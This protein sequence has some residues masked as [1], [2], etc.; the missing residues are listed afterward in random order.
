MNEFLIIKKYLSKLSQGNRGSLKLSDDIFFDYKK[1]IAISVDTFVEK[2]HFLD[3]KNSNL[4][5]K[6]ILR[7]SISDLICKGIKPKYYFIAFSGN[8][9]HLNK[10][11]LSKIYFSL[12][13]E[14]KKYNIILSGGDISFS[15]KLSI[16]ITVVGYSNIK[17]ILRSGAKHNDDIYITNNVGDSFVGQLLLKNKINKSIKN[18]KYFINSFYRPDL[19]FKFSKKIHLFANSSIDLSDGLFQD[20][21]HVLSFSNLTSI[22]Y[23]KNI[24]ISSKLKAYLKKYKKNKLNFISNGD[25][26]QIL[27]TANSNKRKLINQIS[28]Q[29][30][31]KVTKIGIVK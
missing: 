11:K 25:D 22:I 23:D 30:S 3:F 8:K 17:P 12:K 7:S 6:K 26:Y 14:Q 9:R 2:V 24:P 31:T 20:L 21:N 16:T 15:N 1:G 28:K 18:K 19:P 5:I 13:Q 27:F 10:K 29:T 4:V